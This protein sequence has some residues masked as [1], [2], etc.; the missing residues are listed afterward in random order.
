[1]GPK[2]VKAQVVVTSRV[3]GGKVAAD[4]K[5]TEITRIKALLMADTVATVSVLKGVQSKAVTT[6]KA[7]KAQKAED[8]S[9]RVITAATEAMHPKADTNPR[10]LTKLPRRVSRKRKLLLMLK[11][12]STHT[13]LKR[14]PSKRNQLQ[15]QQRSTKKQLSMPNQARLRTRI[16]L[17]RQSSQSLHQNQQLCIR[18][19][20]NM[21]NQARPSTRIQPTKRLS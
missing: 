3:V 10:A 17:T 7:I 21:S 20:Q 18:R 15:N 5:A 16:P 14:S 2:A 12:K 1:M 8:T 6:I 9:R 4:I 11:P 13:R 19:L